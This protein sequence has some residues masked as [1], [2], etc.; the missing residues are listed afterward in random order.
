MMKIEYIPIELINIDDKYQRVMETAR[1]QR[2]AA[3]YED[4]IANPLKVAQR[5]DGSYWVWDG[6]H[7]LS[8]FAELEYKEVPCLISQ[9]Q[10]KEEEARWFTKQQESRKQLSSLDKYKSGIVAKDPVYLSIRDT[11]KKCGWSVGS[12][13]SHNSTSAVEQLREF[14]SDGTLESVLNICS[15]VWG[16]NGVKCGSARIIGGLGKVFRANPDL[17][18]NR[19]K[20]ALRKVTPAQLEA[21]SAIGRT[22]VAGTA[23]NIVRQYNAGKGRFKKLSVLDD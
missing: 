15:E 9:S 5:P 14:D 7:T 21:T 22:Y 12:S 11:V 6:Q 2:Y 16:V 19:L 18:E 13:S 10:G 23:D 20:S 4:V 8:M 1:A 3:N 17:D